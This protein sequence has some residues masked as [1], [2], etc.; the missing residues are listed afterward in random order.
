VENRQPVGAQKAVGPAGAA[1]AVWVTVAIGVV[2]LGLRLGYVLSSDARMIFPDEE[3]YMNIAQNSVAGNGLRVS[4]DPLTGRRVDYAVQRPP[5][6]PLMLAVVLKFNGNVRAVQVVQSVIGALTCVM[7]LVLGK[8]LLGEWPGRIAGGIAAVYPF[9]IYFT[10][11]MLSETLF[12]LLAVTSW[13]FVVRMWDELRRRERWTRWVASCLVAGLLAAAAVLTRPEA[14]AV[15]VMVPV[16]MVLAGPRRLMGLAL[17]L[18]MVL[19]IAVGMSP[20]VA[21]NYLVT[22]IKQQ[23][24]RDKKKVELVRSGRFVLT[25]LKVGESLYEAV[26]PWATGGPNKENTFWP[27]HADRLENDEW[28]R[29]SYLR[30]Q[31]V[32]FMRTDPKRVV[33]LAGIKFLR[34]WNIFPNYQEARTPFYKIVSAAAVIPILLTALLGLFVAM[35]RPR[36]VLW[37]LTPV[38]VITVIHMIFVGSIRY[39]LAMMPFVMV[40]SG[41]GAWWIVC[42]LL[43]RGA[44]E[45]TL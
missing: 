7:I 30:D 41:A 23:S 24:A 3:Q 27:E 43:K 4:L 33:R 1:R 44:R 11:R 32:T 35:K 5:V 26:G 2:A 38:A 14:L 29:D 37:L 16:V 12:L 15:F 36:T 45:V 31:A 10:G 18:L 28:A 34:T 6:Y 17:G 19:V 25:T 39:R 42:K 13:Y 9:S 20:W 21:R 8:A 22:T 40:L